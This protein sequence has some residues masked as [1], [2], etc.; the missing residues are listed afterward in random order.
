MKLMTAGQPWT[1]RTVLIALLVTFGIIFAVNGT[2]VYFAVSTWPGL[3]QSDAYEKGLR[4]NEVI[5]E[6]Q[7]QKELGWRS[8]VSIARNGAIRVQLLDR[9]GRSVDVKDAEVTIERPLGDVAARTISL[10]K[11]ADGAFSA[12][13][14]PLPSGIWYATV[15]AAGARGASYHMQHLIEIR[16]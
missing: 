6:A 7:I 15:S 4:Y 1:G 11:N 16:S 2:F 5:R 14:T 9:D 12:Q 10:S 3:S 13:T 8:D